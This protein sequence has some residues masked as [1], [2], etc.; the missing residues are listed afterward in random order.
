MLRDG[1]AVWDLS[2]NRFDIVWEEAPEFTPAP[3]FTV[4]IL[5]YRVATTLFSRGR[6]QADLFS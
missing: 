1:R 4:A 6:K 2:S 3:L 5:T